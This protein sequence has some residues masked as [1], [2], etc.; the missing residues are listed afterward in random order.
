MYAGTTAEYWTEQ[1]SAVFRLWSGAGGP[2]VL[3]VG[4]PSSLTSG[5][6]PTP[7][8]SAGPG[9]ASDEHPATSAIAVTQRVI[10]ADGLL[11]MLPF[12][13]PPE[14]FPSGGD[15]EH[16]AP[17]LHPR[18]ATFERG[19]PGPSRKRPIDDFEQ[20]VPPQLSH[21]GVR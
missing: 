11:P 21:H 13:S 20:A 9:A 16:A 19:R 6:V 14:V 17:R 5:G 18:E 1:S 15:V 2:G 10:E 4:F 8:P 7:S 3:P 12:A